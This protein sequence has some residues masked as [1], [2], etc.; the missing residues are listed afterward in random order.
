MGR[1]IAKPINWL[2][3]LG[4]IL[5]LTKV[6]ANAESVLVVR[7]SKI[8]ALVL[9]RSER[10]SEASQPPSGG[11]PLW[12]CG[13]AAT[14]CATRCEV[15]PKTALLRNPKLIVLNVNKPRFKK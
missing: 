4:F 12:G 15:N 2:L 1:A 11:L 9:R 3:L 7:E 13:S 10:G 8:R 5:L 6:A 14:I